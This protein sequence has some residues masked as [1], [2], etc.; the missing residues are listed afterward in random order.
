MMDL[1][2]GYLEN[3]AAAAIQKSS[4]GGPITELAAS[5]E[6][7]VDTV[8]RQQQEIKRFSEQVNA[9]KKRGTQAARGSTFPGGT[10]V[11]THCEAV[12]RTLPHRKNDC[13]FDPKKLQTEK[14]GRENS[15][16]EKAWHA[17]MT[18]DDWGQCKQ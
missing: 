1:L 16:M 8:S 11:C 3:I 15:W 5:L 18:N 2:E 7:S 10:T 6:I 14:T 12:G 9:L 13:Y 4:N 17:K